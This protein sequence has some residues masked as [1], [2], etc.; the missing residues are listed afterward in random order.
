MYARLDSVLMWIERIERAVFL[1]RYVQRFSARERRI[2]NYKNIFIFYIIHR[3]ITLL[4]TVI[5]IS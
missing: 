5:V 4:L 2:C 1:R 3:A